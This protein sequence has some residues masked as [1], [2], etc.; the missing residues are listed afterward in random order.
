ML[1]S[2]REHPRNH[3]L[4]ALSAGDYRVIGPRLEPVV[5]Q[6]KE[7]LITPHQPVDEIVFIESGVVSELARTPEGRRIEVGVVGSEGFVGVPALLDVDSTPNEVRV[8]I[9]GQ[10]L[11]LSRTDFHDLLD[12]LPALHQLLTR[13]VHVLHL[14]TAETAV[15]NGIRTLDERLARWLLMCHDRIDGDEIPVTH[16]ALSTML[17]VRRPGVTTAL[18]IMEG[19]GMLRGRRSHV[20]ILDR[21]KLARL[22]SVAYGMPEREYQRL[23]GAVHPSVE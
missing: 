19:D 11:R 15:A 23:L 2:S 21:A 1:T 3:L 7:M 13:Y 8:H 14:Q 18:H 20:Q 17:G 22:A 16:E 4:A 12:R 6:R 5:L 9:E 10:G